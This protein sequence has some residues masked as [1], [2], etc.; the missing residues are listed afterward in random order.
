MLSESNYLGRTFAFSSSNQLSTTVTS[1]ARGDGLGTWTSP[2]A[3]PPAVSA[4]T[5]TT[6][7]IRPSRVT[8]YVRGVTGAATGNRPL[9][10]ASDS[11]S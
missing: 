9:A 5:A 7:M 8:S 2:R 6:L 3:A 1:G 11:R 10:P 4:L